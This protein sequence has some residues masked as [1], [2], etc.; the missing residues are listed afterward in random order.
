MFI[1]YVQ[2]M[3]I[4]FERILKQLIKTSYKKHNVLSHGYT[5]SQKYLYKYYIKLQTYIFTG[6]PKN[7]PINI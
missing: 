2:A 1:K 5:V 6:R 3:I 7:N 4:G